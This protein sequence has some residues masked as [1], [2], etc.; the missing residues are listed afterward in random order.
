MNTLSQAFIA[1]EY[2]G[3]SPTTLANR[4]CENRGMSRKLC[5]FLAAK[6]PTITEGDWMFSEGEQLR[7]KLFDYF[8]PLY[9]K[10]QS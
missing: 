10:S 3:V 2:L 1:R 5:V 4:L 8:S 6:T 7:K 9:E